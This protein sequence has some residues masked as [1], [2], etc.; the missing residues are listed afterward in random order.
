M[1]LA[2]RRRRCLGPPAA[3]VLTAVILLST[4]CGKK[5]PPPPPLRRGPDRRTSVSARQEGRGVV[6][7]GLLPQH[8]Q[9]GGPLTPLEEVR[10]WRLDR[11]GLTGFPG[12]EARSAQRTALRQFTKDAKRIATLSG[13][14][15]AKA[16]SGRRFAFVDPDPLGGEIPEA[17]KDLTY[18]LTAVD[19][20]KRSSPLSNFAALRL[21]PPPLPPGNLRSELSEK[22]IRLYW[23]APPPQAQ[24]ISVVFNVYRSE[25][26]GLFLD[27][28]RNSQPLA[29]P[30]F[31][32]TNFTF[33]KDYFYSVRSVAVSGKASRESE[34]SASLRVSPK[35]I[36][37]PAAPTG[38]AVS[39][40]GQ[41][42][43][44]YWFPNSEADL[45]G[46][47]IYRSESDSG[48]FVELARAGPGESTYEDTA[49]QAGVKYY[50][51]MT[52]VDSAE[53]PN[54]SERSEVRTDRIAPQAPGGEKPPPGKP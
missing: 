51:T 43:K 34:G 25:T 17:G 3:A 11:G 19:I 38:F 16:L 21:L 22:A 1:R 47:R 28:P 44:I 2:W 31:E 53:P 48:E 10:V 50:Y 33:G 29:Q 4:A 26:E 35:D 45:A 52:A 12:A 32:E 7:T 6:L 15:L 46:Y 37:A 8:S 5:G 24:E 30:V 42:I 9:D 27:P 41:V 40:E 20:E 23:E 54:E 36:Y 18:A 13:E 14:P 39:A 49:V